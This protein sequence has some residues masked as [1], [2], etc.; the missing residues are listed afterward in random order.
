ME[1]SDMNGGLL[2]YQGD[3]Y[4]RYAII[5]QGIAVGVNKRRPRRE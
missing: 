5:C 3:V 1:V 4:L 2:R